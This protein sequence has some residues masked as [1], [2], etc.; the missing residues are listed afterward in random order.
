MLESHR[1]WIHIKNNVSHKVC[2]LVAPV[3]ND[4]LIA[5]LKSYNL[6]KSVLV[7]LTLISQLHDS[8]KATLCWH[9]FKN[10]V[11][12]KSAPKLTLESWCLK[13]RK[14]LKLLSLK[15]NWIL[16]I[17]KARHFSNL[18]Q[19]CFSECLLYND[20]NQALRNRVIWV[21]EVVV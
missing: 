17:K 5:K 15:L 11:H 14:N 9:K 10:R 2:S 6:L 7:T 13:T 16:N 20:V 1:Y 21:L 12:N 19:I 3:C 8:L 4:R 18:L